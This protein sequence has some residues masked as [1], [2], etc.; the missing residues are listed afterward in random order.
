MKAGASVPEKP[1][2]LYGPIRNAS[3]PFLVWLF[4]NFPKDVCDYN[5]EEEEDSLA[6]NEPQVQY[7]EEY[8]D[9]DED[10]PSS[11]Q[12]QKKDKKRVIKRKWNP[13][14]FLIYSQ[15]GFYKY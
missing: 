2:P 13:L 9:S 1:Y 12:D 14:H 10:Q 6:N 4:K 11:A 3:S 15:G 8:E 7:Y 5:K